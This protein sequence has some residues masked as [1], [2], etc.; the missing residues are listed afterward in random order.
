MI[1]SKVSLDTFYKA[2]CHF[3]HIAYNLRLQGCCYYFCLR[4]PSKLRCREIRK[5]KATALYF[6]ASNAYLAGRGV[7][8]LSDGG[9]VIY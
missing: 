9:T 3:V 5:H 4:I 6:N 7:P 1:H 8:S 2:T